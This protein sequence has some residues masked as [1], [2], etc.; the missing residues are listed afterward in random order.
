MN[1][2]LKSCA[3]AASALLLILGA[4]T[5]TSCIP[6]AMDWIAS[7]TGNDD[8]G[9]TGSGE[10]LVITVDDQLS[11]TLV[12]SID[13]TAASY[14]ITGRGPDGATFTRTTTGATVQI[15]KL[16]AGLWD[17][18]AEALNAA[19]KVIGNGSTQVTLRN[20]TP[21]TASI[22][23]RPLS[24]Y[25]SLQLTINWPA[26]DVA[27]PSVTAQ[28][29]PA[30][31]AARNLTFTLGSGTATST[32]IDIPTGYHTLSL[33]LLDGGVLVAGAI[34][35]ARIVKDEI[36][37]GVFTFDDVNPVTVNMQVSIT[38]ALNDPLTVTMT[39]QQSSVVEGTG[40][41]ARA[42]VT[43]YTGNLVYAW[44]LNSVFGT[45]GA[46]FNV[47]A[48]LVPGTYRMDVTAFAADGSRAGS[49]TASF[50]VT[51]APQQTQV[52]LA[53]DAS[54]DSTVTGYKL[55]YGT[56]AGVYNQTIDV[57]NVT[58]YTVTGLQ[59][60]VTYYFVATAYCGATGMESGY[61]NQ[62]MFN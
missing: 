25:G 36:T 31:G 11:R 12:P 43:G 10:A 28:L 34:E 8:S 44:Y 1:K 13:M 15:D 33:Q 6:H 59:S 21:T 35:V 19:P 57:A 52:T 2:L 9:Q 58:T 22:Q 20:G 55:H 16:A 26:A 38:P 32:T 40:F 45:T 7:D 4:L 30:A 14:A 39:G 17:V 47:P 3:P 29:I 41:T 37:S 51:P 27:S 48:D 60:G 61:S 62:V 54:T 46:N 23:V 49:K 50:T 53:W 42:A 24:G 18:A 5:L 56:A